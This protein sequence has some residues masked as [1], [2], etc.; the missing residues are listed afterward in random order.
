M[1]SD[2]KK[3]EKEL[4]TLLSNNHHNFAK[5]LWHTKKN[6]DEW[7]LTNLS[8]AGY[9]SV[10]VGYMAFLM[11]IGSEGITNNNLA[12]KIRVSKQAMSK[13]S[14]ELHGLGLIELMPNIEDARSS[15]I[16]LTLEGM[17]M[18]IHARKKVNSLSEKYQEVIGK[19][20]YFDMLDSLIKIIDLHQSSEGS[21]SFSKFN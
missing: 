13:T 1:K 15:F 3:L 2:K 6:F 10:K 19:K 20:R 21:S 11:N 18:V 7:C 14:K 8:E 12:K 4:N 9:P 17:K 5:I 16:N